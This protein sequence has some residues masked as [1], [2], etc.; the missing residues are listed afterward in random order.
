MEINKVKSVGHQEDAL[1]QTITANKG[2]CNEDKTVNVVMKTEQEEKLLIKKVEKKRKLAD[3]SNC[4]PKTKKKL[5]PCSV[6]KRI[7]FSN[8]TLL[9]H[10]RRYHPESC[11]K[12]LVRFP[13][14]CETC[15]KTFITKDELKSHRVTHSNK[16]NNFACDVC[17]VTFKHRQSLTNHKTGKEHQEM[18]QFVHG[19]GKVLK[20]KVD[21]EFL[22]FSNTLAGT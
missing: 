18:L 1:L 10:T 20:V 15:G 9:Q 13:F 17:L 16:N 2:K 11:P 12:N 3:D 14:K 22:P 4:K 21:K 8:S 6:C 5:Y 19:G 7:L